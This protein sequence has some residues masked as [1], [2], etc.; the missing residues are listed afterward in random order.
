MQPR[1]INTIQN[2]KYY[3]MLYDQKKKKKENSSGL[4]VFFV[5]LVGYFC[6]FGISFLG[7]TKYGV[8]SELR[9]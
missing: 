3:T 5:C 4:I 6:L 7:L 8:L 9:N 1:N 2:M